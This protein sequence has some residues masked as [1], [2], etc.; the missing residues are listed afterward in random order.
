MVTFL[1]VG[2][3]GDVEPMAV[4]AGAVAATGRATTVVA[5]DE[6]RDLV[7]SH[8]AGFRGIGPGL[9]EVNRLGAGWIGRLAYRTPLAQ[10][11]LLARWLLGLAEPL[12]DALDEVPAASMVVTG[13]AS[14]DAALALV[15]ARGCRMATVLH[16]AVL[17]TTQRV[18][19]LEGHQF[20]GTP[21]M[22][23]AFTRW[24]WNQVASLS[25]QTSAAFRRRAG[26]RRPRGARPVEEAD[27]HPVWL[28]ADPVLIPSAADWP[29]TVRQTGAIRPTGRPVWSP[30]EPLRGFL[31][32]GP[33]PVYVGLGSLND[34]GGTGWLDLIR[35][36][37]RA[38]G[39]RVLTPAPPGEAA[40]VV[41][42][43]V[44]TVGDLPHDQLFGTLA[45]V[46]H[47]GGAG[48]TAAALR[49]G[50]PSVAAPAVFD[51]YYHGRRLAELGVGPRPVPLHRLDAARL[52]GLLDAV[53]SD[54]HRDRAAQV[55]ERARAVDGTAAT[56]A[57]L[58]QFSSIQDA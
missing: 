21:A 57:E 27:R 41:D 33:P 44:C 37:A 49:A 9:A 40:G 4:L 52:A 13:V 55:G 45:G 36:A 17:P 11:V 51:Q 50:V 46:V 42:D 48:S 39:R 34:S 5:V 1:A 35:R 10:P 31:D 12:A 7:E 29:A 15:E 24:Y 58:G 6:Y 2:S 54:V 28:A 16:T 30:P 56:L 14:R 22:I 8:G 26:L 3:R 18:S 23:R 25:R 32:D 19:H 53:A 20:R 47:H 38:S 43:L